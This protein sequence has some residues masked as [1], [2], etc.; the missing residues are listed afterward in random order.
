MR[1]PGELAAFYNP[2]SIFVSIN[3]VKLLFPILFWNV[4]LGQ[5]F[6]KL[7]P[8]WTCCKTLVTCSLLFLCLWHAFLVFYLESPTFLPHPSL[9]D[10]LIV[11][12]HLQNSAR[13]L[14]WWDAFPELH[15]SHLESLGNHDTTVHSCSLTSVLP[16]YVHSLRSLRL[17]TAYLALD[18]CSIN[19]CRI[20]AS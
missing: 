4:S 1:L 16:Y 18:S 13:L 12:F 15:H 6:S 20:I 8:Q 14:F 19:V 9:N 11:I 10:L 17:P 2:S 3:S 5:I 7:Q